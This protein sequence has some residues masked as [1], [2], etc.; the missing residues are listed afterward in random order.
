M[1]TSPIVPTVLGHQAER[2]I[3]H[4]VGVLTSLLERLRDDDWDRPGPQGDV[5]WTVAHLGEG[6]E[7]LAHAVKSRL[8]VEEDDALLHTFDDPAEPST[9]EVD[10]ADRG[11][12]LAIYRAGT[13]ALQEALGG[14]LEA[15]WSWPVW[16]P[17][18]GAETLAEAARRWVTHHHVHNVDVHVALG[19]PAPDDDDVE[20]LAAEFV[21]DA[22]AR[23]GG[24]AVPPPLSIEVVTSLPGAGSWTLIFSEER[25]RVDVEDVWETLVGHHPDA[26]E[27]HRVEHGTDDR[28]RLRIKARG[29]D[30]WRIAFRRGGAWADLEVHGDDEARQ[31]W[32]Q[33]VASVSGQATAGIGRVQH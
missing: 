6:A 26:K 16:S 14:V 18:G 10:T 1:S 9:V 15:D 7:R 19:R 28:A 25:D 23:R 8:D 29:G 20:R 2:A 30:L 22:I 3:R 12:V 5:A 32:D 11:A 24:D 17:L 31:L 21:L 27:T 13:A 4:D 33:L